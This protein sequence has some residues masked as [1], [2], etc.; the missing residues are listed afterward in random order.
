MS[1]PLRICLPILCLMGWVGSAG[2]VSAATV[3]VENFTGFGN[4]IAALQAGGNQQQVITA[5]VG[6]GA[7]AVSAIDGTSVFLTIDTTDTPAIGS[8]SYGGGLRTDITG[9]FAAGDLTSTVATDY[10]IV[11]DVAAVGFSPNN[12][13]LFLQFRDATNANV[14][15]SQLSL[16]QNNPA[17]AGFVAQLGSGDAPVS[18]SLGL[19]EFGGLPSDLSGLVNADRIQFQLFSRSLDANYSS[20]AGNVLV[21]DNVGVALTAIPEPS[22]LLLM[23][24][25]GVWAGV[26]RRPSVIRR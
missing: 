24:V 20:G 16:N 9:A 12:V 25:A 7:G 23:L 1:M 11:F 4:S 8:G 19:D 6:T 13:D 21:L 22:S 2:R 10:Q 14:L 3:F 5:S 26:R 15:G 18:V 17:F